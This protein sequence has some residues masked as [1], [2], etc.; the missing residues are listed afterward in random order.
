V[1]APIAIAPLFSATSASVRVADA[2]SDADLDAVVATIAPGTLLVG[3]RGLGAALARRLGRPALEPAVAPATSRLL[4][5]IGSRDP[6]TARQLEHLRRRHPGVAMVEAVD[7]QLSADDLELPLV[8]YCGGSVV[9]AKAGIVAARFAEGIAGLVRRTRPD[10]LWMSGGETALAILDALAVSLVNLVG[11][12]APGVPL[13]ACT[14]A[15]GGRLDCVLK[16]GG[17]GSVDVLEAALR[18]RG[19]LAGMVTGG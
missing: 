7:G 3:A 6:I 14:M 12:V 11:E 4:M 19:A 8:L 17:F 10:C 16:S 2:R 1:A 9:P 18:D 13:V 5:A 15:D